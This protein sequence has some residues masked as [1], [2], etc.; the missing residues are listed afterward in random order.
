MNA[1]DGR[2][3]IMAF[4]GPQIDEDRLTDE[5]C[6]LLRY[7]FAFRERCGDDYYSNRLLSHFLLHCDLG[8]KVADR[9]PGRYQSAHG[10]APA[11][12]LVQGGDSGGA[13]HRMA[14]RPHGKLLPRYAGPI[15][16]FIPTHAGR[17]RATM[18]SISI[19]PHL[20]RACVDGC[21]APLLQEVRPGSG[22][23]CRSRRCSG[24]AWIVRSP[25][26]APAKRCR[27]ASP[28]PLPPLPFSRRGRNSR[29]RVP[30]DAAGLG[31]VGHGLKNVSQTTT[32]PCG[33]VC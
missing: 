14:G 32:A 21:L 4:L 3:R 17:H 18:F 33:R 19:E 20:E 7:V 15:A 1:T 11:R 25:S 28:V 30:L 31:L 12:G 13:H 2:I 9:P 27:Q 5:Q 6:G 26:H 10:F 29:G 23:A 24:P 8:L 16:E 22:H